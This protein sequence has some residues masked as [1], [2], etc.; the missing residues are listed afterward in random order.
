MIFTE[1]T[2]ALS[3]TE[4]LALGKAFIEIVA[5]CALVNPDACI[6]TYFPTASGQS[7]E[8]IPYSRHRETSEAMQGISAATGP[9]PESDKLKDQSP[10]KVKEGTFQEYFDEN[11]AI[12]I[13][14][15]EGAFVVEN[16]YSITTSRYFAIPF[17]SGADARG[18]FFLFAHDETEFLA[19]S[20]ALDKIT[21]GIKNHFNK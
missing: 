11:G 19:L 3:T 15:H 1:S 12:S 2:P 20:G 9:M 6:T 7:I 4:N 21:E 5:G 17:P 18:V 14:K 8:A 13:T 10:I 16:N